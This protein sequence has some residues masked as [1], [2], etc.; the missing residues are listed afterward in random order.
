MHAID[1]LSVTGNSLYPNFITPD[2][3]TPVGPATIPDALLLIVFCDICSSSLSLSFESLDSKLISNFDYYF[4]DGRP[5]RYYN[6]RYYKPYNI[7]DY[8]RRPWQDHR[9]RIYRRKAIWRQERHK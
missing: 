6:H 9:H 1:R 5:T 4:Q 2:P 7:Y 8:N 3:V